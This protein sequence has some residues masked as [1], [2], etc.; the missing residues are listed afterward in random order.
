MKMYYLHKQKKTIK[1]NFLKLI[2][3]QHIHK[4]Y[5]KRQEK[6]RTFIKCFPCTQDYVW[7]RPCELL[8][9]FYI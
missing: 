2:R 9:L 5:Y 1:I 4:V 3:N 6:E 7:H 8:F